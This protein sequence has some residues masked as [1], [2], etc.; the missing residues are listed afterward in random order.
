MLENV[1]NWKTTLMGIGSAVV[2]LL[3]AFGILGT[4][5]SAAVNQNLSTII[6]AVIALL[7]AIP[8]IWLIFKSKDKD[9]VK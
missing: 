1:K 3:V 7:S 5:Q 6:D 8:A 4:D 2:A 9:P